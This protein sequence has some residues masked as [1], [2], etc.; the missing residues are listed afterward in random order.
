M[1]VSDRD[2]KEQNAMYGTPGLELFSTAGDGGIRG[3]YASANGRA[4]AV[5]AGILYEIDSAGTATSRGT[6]SSTSGNVTIAENSVQLIICDG[7]AGYTF[8][9]SSNTFATI[10]DGDFPVPG[11]VTVIDGY[12]VVNSVNTGR[13]YISSVN[14]ATAWAALDFANA[15]SSPDTLKRVLN[16]MGQLWLF[17]D[18]TTEIKTNTGDTA[19]PFQTLG[20]T[21]EMGILAVHSAQAA[22]NAVF[23]VGKDNNGAGIVLTATGFSP[24]RISTEAIELLISKATDPTNM[25][26]YMY[27]EEG[28]TFYVLTGGGLATTLV[29]DLSTKL[30][31]E[32]AY[33][34][35]TGEFA[36]HLACCH[37]YAFS[38][39]IVGSRQDGKL[40]NM[41]LDLLDDAG[42]EIARERI[43]TH[44]SDEGRRIR[45][46]RFEIGFEVGV[47]L[48][49]GQ[50]SA[51][52]VSMQLSKDGARTWSDWFTASIG[53]VG[54]YE[55]K[56]EFRRLGIARQMTFKIRITDPVKV[57]ITG[58]YL[59]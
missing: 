55:T 58:S 42:D 28:H 19:F 2:G 16:G 33:L 18:K 1:A 26:S 35:A 52:L 37:M 38:K 56:V 24:E 41:D 47:G 40:Y 30:W 49:T 10:S 53:A 43:Y 12:A 11:S 36:Q 54:E 59:S 17:G 25:T 50:G 6:L 31:H 46:N 48:Q 29:Y 20:N 45:Y 8:V 57:Y 13:Y 34:A 44:I 3:C 14:D 15:E 22:N 23:W 5:S 32:R 51:P 7:A 4:F 9:Y 27:Q 21:I 39:H